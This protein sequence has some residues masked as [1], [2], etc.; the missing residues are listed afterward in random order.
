MQVFHLSFVLLLPGE[1][2]N[3]MLRDEILRYAQNDKGTS[4]L[5]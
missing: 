1:R 4:V 3:H 5:W 2:G